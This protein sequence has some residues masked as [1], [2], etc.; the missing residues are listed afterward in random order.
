VACARASRRSRTLPLPIRRLWVAA[1]LCRGT[2]PAHRDRETPADGLTSVTWDEF[3][4]LVAARKFALS[5]ERPLSD[6][7]S[8]GYGCL[9]PSGG[10]V[11]ILMPGHGIYTNKET[12][13]PPPALKQ[14]L[15]VGV[16]APA[17]VRAERLRVRSPDVLTS[18]SVCPGVLLEH[19]DEAMAA[20]RHI[21]EEFRHFRGS[22]SRGLCRALS[23]VL[24]DVGYEPGTTRPRA[25]G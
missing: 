11:P 24:D 1:K 25:A 22:R 21:S 13:R 12:L 15:V 16:A 17:D 7:S 10:S 3:R 5:W 20:N 6:G 14:A 18:S 23:L 9:A 4:A 19:D 2:R 8:I